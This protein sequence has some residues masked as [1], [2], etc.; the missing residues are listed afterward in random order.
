LPVATTAQDLE[1]EQGLGSER[2][3]SK[4][5]FMP[6]APFPMLSGNSKDSL[7]YQVV[8][9][10]RAD[11]SWREPGMDDSEAKDQ[12]GVTVMRERKIGKIRNYPRGRPS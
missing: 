6:L 9:V 10:G 11:L 4:V 3:G 7:L 2:D 5:A 12:R 8:R 1:F